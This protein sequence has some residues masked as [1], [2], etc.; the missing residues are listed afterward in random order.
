[1]EIQIERAIPIVE[2]IRWKR[3]AG[4]TGDTATQEA[5]HLPQVVMPGLRK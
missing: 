1:M 3:E 4:L 5:E 2:Q